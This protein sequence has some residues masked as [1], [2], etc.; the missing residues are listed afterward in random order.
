VEHFFDWF[1]R[2]DD[3]ERPWLILGKG[4]SFGLRSRFDLSGYHLLSLNHAV[5]E[6]SVLLSHMIDLN[7]VDACGEALLSQARYVVLPWYPHIE[8]SPGTRPLDQLVGD[9]PLLG[10]LAAEGR[11]LWY[12]L[13]TASRRYGP[14]PVVQATYFS[15]EAAVSLLALA[16][17]RRVRSLGVDGGSSYSTDFSDLAGHTLLANGQSGFDL[18]FRGIARTILRTGVDFAPLDQPSPIVA[19]V[20]AG[21]QTRLA[22]EVLAFSVRKHTSMTVRILAVQAAGINDSITSVRGE[23]SRQGPA[24]ARRAIVLRSGSLVLDDLRKLWMRPVGAEGVEV[25]EKSNGQEPPAAVAVITAF[26]P[27]RLGA[28]VRAALD[29]RHRQEGLPFANTLPSSWDR[30][31][32]LADANTSLVVYDAPGLQPWISRGHP[33]AHLWVATLLEAVQAGAVSIDLVRSEVRL[34]RVRPSL[35]EQ[36]E[37]GNPESL[38][39]SWS[40]RRRDADFPVPEPGANPFGFLSRPLLLFRALAR[41]AHR[42]LRAYRSRGTAQPS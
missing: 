25:P 21:E 28:A 22:D 31:D 2:Q 19:Y 29:V 3:R 11:L 9:H 24:V 37:R 23:A 33:L 10:R 35:L 41:Q 17:V 18:Q 8:N 30:R 42:Q 6:Q 32:R 5:R 14:G 13:S 20:A 26:T 40:A 16:G 1:K 15:A 4:P 38:L 39:L 36:V 7:V 12:D 27:E 34:G